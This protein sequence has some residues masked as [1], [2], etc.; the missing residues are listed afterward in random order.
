MKIL[1]AFLLSI[2]YTASVQAQSP[3]WSATKNWKIYAGEGQQVF[4]YPIDTLKFLSCR[5][6]DQDTL[7]QFLL[8]AQMLGK[9]RTPTWMGSYLASYESPNGK[10]NKV[11]VSIYGGFFYDQSSGTYYQLPR[12]MINDWLAYIIQN[13]KAIQQ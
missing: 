11:E 5:K 6:L 13:M 12:G 2:L 7:H 8:G 10:I 4:A 9:D 1:I 3:T